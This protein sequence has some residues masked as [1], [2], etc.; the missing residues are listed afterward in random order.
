MSDSDASAAAE[1][2]RAKAAA[3]QAKL[4]AKSQAR[5]DKITGAAK[6]EG[7]VISDSSVGIAPKVSSPTPTP[8]PPSIKKVPQ[9]PSTLSDLNHSDDPAEIDLAALKGDQG[10]EKQLGAFGLGGMNPEKGFQGL[11]GGPPTGMDGGDM[12]AQMMAQMMGGGAGGDGPNATSPL[13]GGGGPRPAPGSTAFAP[14]APK[15]LLD[16]LLPLIHLLSMIGLS[17]YAIVYMEPTR[18]IQ[19]VYGA[20]AASTADAGID[21]SAWG[22]LASRR[23][24]ANG[25]VGQAVGLQLASVPLLWMFVTV[26]LVLQTT[27]AFLVRNRPPPPGLLTTVLPILSQFSPRAGLVVETGSK[28]VTLVSTCVN[29]LA[30]VI[31]CVGAFVLV[32]RY[33]TGAPS[34]WDQ[35]VQE[36]VNDVFA[37]AKGDL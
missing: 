11:M 37:K 21:W 30:V 33:K 35:V 7:R 20:A 25:V 26:E 16:K 34:G 31:F 15:T 24:V 4:L 2:R 36:T 27:R 18:R 8:A 1:D 17:V 9:G 6:G 14:P 12:F 28:Y 10:L 23:P 22:A 29:D 13:A 5:L 3:R 32:G 19:N